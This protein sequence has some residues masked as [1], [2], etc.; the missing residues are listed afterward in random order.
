[1]GENAWLMIKHKDEFATGEDVTK[2]DQSVLSGK[3]IETMAKQ[4]TKF[5]SMAMRKMLY[6]T[7]TGGRSRNNRTGHIQKLILEK[8]LKS[9]P[10]SKV[11]A[12]IKPMKATLVDEPFDEPGWLFEVKWDGYR[13]VANLSKK[14]GV[15]LDLQEQSAL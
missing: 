3:T 11:P 12:N 5:G 4:V 10:K 14:D 9:A 2:H 6:P 13:A 1:M 7:R 15:Q 8:I